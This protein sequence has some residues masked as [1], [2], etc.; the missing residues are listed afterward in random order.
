MATSAMEAAL[1]IISLVILAPPCACAH[2]TPGNRVPASPIPEHVFMKF[3]RS[4]ILILSFMQPRG[5]ARKIA[6][7]AINH[8]AAFLV[9]ENAR[10]QRSADGLRFFFPERN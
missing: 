5:R 1:S 7:H 8:F 3:R 10:D 6:H 4:S 9:P 2:N